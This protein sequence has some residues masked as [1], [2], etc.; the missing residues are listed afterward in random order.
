MTGAS[1]NAVR[2]RLKVA[3]LLYDV[4]FLE[5]GMVSIQAGPSGA[6]SMWR[7]VPS[8]ETVRWQTPRERGVARQHRFE[9]LI[10]TET[11]P[12]VTAEHMVPLIQS[13]TSIRWEAT[14]EPFKQE[15]PRGCGW[16]EWVYS[17]D[18][19]GEPRRL[20]DKWVRNDKRNLALDNAIPEQFV[21][22]RVVQNA[23]RDLVVA[24][25]AACAASQDGLHARVVVSRFEDEH[26]DWRLTGYALP[27]LI[28]DVAELS[29]EAVATIRKERALQQLRGIMEEVEAETSDVAVRGGDLE[30][31][32]HHAVETRLA[33][34]AGKVDT[35]AGTSKR[36]AVGFVIGAASGVATMGITG[37]LG[38]LA[39]TALGSVTGGV[40]DGLAMVRERRATQWVS[41]LNRLREPV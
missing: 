18:P 23:N 40:L 39:S 32:V 2:R 11:T 35:V 5:S 10:G 41:L 14:F 3:S 16:L 37:P 25:G 28:P 9:F 22:S 34:V 36:T 21:R 7:P 31:A 19:R 38:V 30:A 17:E 1:L 27:I 4:V 33:N 29:W 8:G 26:S 15:I 12:G 20:L 24:I 13:D 6:S